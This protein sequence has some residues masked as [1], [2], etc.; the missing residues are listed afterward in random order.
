MY[1]L[2]T[3]GNYQVYF[4]GWSRKGPVCILVF[5]L[6]LFDLKTEGFKAATAGNL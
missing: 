6:P 5:F 1:L 2:A 4:L 3:K